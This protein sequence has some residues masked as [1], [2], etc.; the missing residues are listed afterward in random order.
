LVA[1]LLAVAGAGGGCYTKRMARMEGTLDTLRLDVDQLSRNQAAAIES[2]QRALEQQEELMHQLRAGTNLASQDLIER[3]EIL[4]AK[5]DDTA[6]RIWRLGLTARVL[7]PA[8][9]DT[10]GGAWA[11]PTAD[12]Q[13][14]YEQAA[15]DFTQGRFE[16]ALAGFR[17]LL[18][19][20][21]GHNY[22]D[23]ALYGI[24]ECFYALAQY[25]SAEVAYRSVA[26]RY[27]RGDKVPASLYKLAMTQE[28]LGRRSEAKQTFERLRKEYPRSGEA[29]LAEERLKEL[30][31][32]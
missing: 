11:A 14:L 21:P 25:D 4:S 9:A 2:L 20:A 6:D 26:E 13:A 32:L 17:Q 22:A 10:A 30:E 29:I 27:P 24:G 8:A 18:A 15:K 16:M 23:N 12:P 19:V 31:R 1:L 3:M 28:K 5:L 7:P